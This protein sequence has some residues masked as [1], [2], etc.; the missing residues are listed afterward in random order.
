LRARICCR[1]SKSTQWALRIKSLRTCNARC[2]SE[3]LRPLLLCPAVCVGQCWAL[4]ECFQFEI[5]RSRKKLKISLKDHWLRGISH[6]KSYLT[7]F[8]TLSMSRI[9]NENIIRAY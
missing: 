6:R 2:W 3:S 9:K 7:E 5:T 4:T 1:C 8:P